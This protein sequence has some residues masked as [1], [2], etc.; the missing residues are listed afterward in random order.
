VRSW[1]GTHQRGGCEPQVAGFCQ[2][3]LRPA[4]LILLLQQL[5]Q[6][7]LLLLLLLLLGLRRGCGAAGRSWLAQRLCADAGGRSACVV[8]HRSSDVAAAVCLQ[9]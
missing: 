8:L 5:L 4:A 1:A 7:Y 6:L 2:T 9:E 3:L